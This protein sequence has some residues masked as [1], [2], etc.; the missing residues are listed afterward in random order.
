M[1]EKI[2]VSCTNVFKSETEAERKENFNT[3]VANIISNEVNQ[4][5]NKQIAHFTTS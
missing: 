3:I 4:H 1:K 5:I 2:K